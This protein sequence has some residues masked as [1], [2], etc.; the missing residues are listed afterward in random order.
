MK[1]LS[2]FLLVVLVNEGR[3]TLID[4][5]CEHETQPLYEQLISDQHITEANLDTLH[6]IFNAGFQQHVLMHQNDAMAQHLQTSGAC[7]TGRG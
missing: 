4:Y 7:R 3:T 5:C 2:N 1:H 6:A